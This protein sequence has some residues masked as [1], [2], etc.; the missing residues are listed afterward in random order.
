MFLRRVFIVLDFELCFRD[1]ELGCVG[2]WGPTL[3][4]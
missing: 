2:L 3:S 4:N 1:S